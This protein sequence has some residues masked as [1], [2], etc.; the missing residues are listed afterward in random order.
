MNFI[1]IKT[2][3][4]DLE[5]FKQ[6]KNMKIIQKIKKY[7]IIGLYGNF[8]RKLEFLKKKKKKKNYFLKHLIIFITLISNL[9]T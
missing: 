8:F 1:I 7:G 3:L 6:L 4:K 5:L 9:K 2:F